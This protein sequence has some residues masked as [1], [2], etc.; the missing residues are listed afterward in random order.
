VPD[1]HLIVLAIGGN[2]LIRDEA[3]R[4]VADQWALTRETCHHVAHIIEA[5]H[6][7][8][9]THGN[10]PQV[11]F[12]LR[13]SELA[14]QELHE[15]P[16]DSC[17]ADT[18]GAIGYM[19]QQSLANEFRRR[20]MNR[21]A[22]TVV[23]QVEVASD[24]PAFILPS[25]PI[26]SFMDEA[27]ARDRAAR[28]GWAIAEAIGHGWRRVVPSPE[29]L[30]IIELD[31]IRH[32]V[33]GGYVVTAVGGGGIPVTRDAAGDLTGVE[34][35]IDKDLASALLARLLGADLF[36]ISTNV[37]QVCLNF[38]KPDQRPLDRVTL[39]EAKRYLAE[40]HFGAGSMAPKIQAIIRFLESGGR[41]AI[42][43]CPPDLEDAV[44]GHAGTEFVAP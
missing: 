17:G 35:V 9:I 13:R 42:V 4:T 39:D 16:L 8:V 37:H 5:G 11:G 7:V 27:T 14:R 34:A 3:H 2:S 19:I 24:S 41:R 15:V 1:S 10:G 29:P 20:G 36:V 32:L 23:T 28:N 18:Q 38:G 21:L 6:H 22:V 31:A 25:K 30:G 44:T 12:I 40:G 26:G 33:E 43:T